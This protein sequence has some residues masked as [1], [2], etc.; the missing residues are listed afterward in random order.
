[1]LDL[2]HYYQQYDAMIKHWHKV[3]PGKILDVHYEE[4]VHDVE[5]QVRRILDFCSLPF[6]QS[7]VDFHQTDRAVKTA[8]SEQVRQP[9]YKGA[10]GTWRHYE[11]FLGLWKE[12]LGEIIEELPN[13]S[14]RAGLD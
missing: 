13:V 8:S 14:K 3:L 1:M 5:S 4:T 10:L 2:A 11:E 6:E 12:Q 7:C 9:I